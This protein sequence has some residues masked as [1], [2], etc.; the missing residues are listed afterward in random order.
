[1]ASLP[2][3]FEFER[4]ID[5]WVFMCFFV[6]NDFLP[7]L[8]SLEI[9]WG[10]GRLDFCV[11]SRFVKMPQTTLSCLTSE[12]S[13][14][15]GRTQVLVFFRLHKQGSWG[16]CW[17]Q[18]DT[19]CHLWGF[20]PPLWTLF[21]S[22]GD[23]KAPDVVTGGE[24]QEMRWQQILNPCLLL[25][26]CPILLLT[27]GLLFT[28]PGVSQR[29]SD[30]STGQHLQRRRAQNRSEWPHSHSVLPVVIFFSPVK[31][32][33]SVCRATWQRTATSTWSESR[34]S[35]RRWAWPRTTSSRNAKR[36][37]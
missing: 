22:E 19:C 26:L 28:F 12:P 34:W 20:I 25:G 7:H 30:R 32:S 9:R 5:D 14:G 17:S 3:P 8:P 35:C 11:E 6:G 1:M 27:D 18:P 37:T 21:C 2:F 29:G 33:V 31:H 13:Q 10:S 16:R 24:Q 4:S 36:T 23:S 15:W